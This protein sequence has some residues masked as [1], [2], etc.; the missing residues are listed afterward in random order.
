MA[1]LELDRLADSAR[2]DTVVPQGW[3]AV[4]GHDGSGAVGAVLEHAARRAGPGGHVIVVHALPGGVSATDAGT[5][6]AYA[7]TAPALLR[8]IQAAL[9][10]ATSYEARI[11]VGPAATALLETAR[12][13]RADEI[14]LGVSARPAPGVADTVL[15]RSEWPVTF[16]PRCA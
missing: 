2:G 1:Q 6:R 15:R 10:R 14:V 11:V 13:C 5:A 16:V 3:T 12:R 7:G 8:S 4:V 9:P